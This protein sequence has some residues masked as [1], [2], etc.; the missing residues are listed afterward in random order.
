MPATRSWSGARVCLSLAA[1]ASH[2]VWAA[3][4]VS[5]S[6]SRRASSKI[7]SGRL[8]LNSG[9][10][11]GEWVRRSAG[12]FA[13]TLTDVHTAF[14]LPFLEISLRTTVRK[15]YTSK[16]R[17]ASVAD[18]E[19]GVS[20]MVQPGKV[21]ISGDSVGP[22]A[23]FLFGPLVWITEAWASLSCIY[24]AVRWMLLVVSTLC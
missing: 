9:N 10:G 19:E 12:S 22:H 24:L 23:E 1:S 4:L 2:S 18:A 5:E 13:P 20:L 14:V 7:D 15:I 21:C 17:A 6:G 3:E 8:T 11:A 16:N